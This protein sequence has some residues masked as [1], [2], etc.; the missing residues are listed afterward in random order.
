VANEW[1]WRTSRPSYLREIEPLAHP[2][3][4]PS[5][6]RKPQAASI[7]AYRAMTNERMRE[8]EE[9]RIEG[10]KLERVRLAAACKRAERLEREGGRGESPEQQRRRA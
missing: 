5:P 7:L 4:W 10:L 9:H 6:D 3:A 1:S 8:A 2:G